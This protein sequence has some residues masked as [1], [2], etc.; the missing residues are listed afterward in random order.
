MGVA[1]VLTIDKWS[2]AYE[3]PSY[4]G[5]PMQRPMCEDSNHVRPA[6]GAPQRMG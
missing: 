4:W 2:F 6:G 1:P 5:T 3:P